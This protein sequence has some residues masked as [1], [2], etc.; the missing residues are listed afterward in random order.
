MGRSKNGQ[1]ISAK[2]RTPDSKA[3]GTV[4]LLCL[5]PCHERHVYQKPRS[6]SRKTTPSPSPLHHAVAGSGDGEDELSLAQ[7]LVPGCL[8]SACEARL[9]LQQVWELVDDQDHTLFPSAVPDL[10]EGVLPTREGETGPCSE[11]GR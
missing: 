8:Q 10:D 5:F 6:K 2:R 7:M 1:A 3:L 9:R 4:L 11:Q